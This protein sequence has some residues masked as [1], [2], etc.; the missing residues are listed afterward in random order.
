MATIVEI[1]SDDVIGAFVICTLSHLSLL[2]VLKLL[3][4]QLTVQ[5]TKLTVATEI[6]ILSRG[7]EHNNESVDCCYPLTV[8]SSL[9]SHGLFRSAFSKC[10]VTSCSQMIFL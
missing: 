1:C 2:S 9:A 4:L 7:S 10:D 5:L 3:L 8:S 6:F